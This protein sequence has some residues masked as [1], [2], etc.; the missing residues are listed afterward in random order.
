MSER[1]TPMNMQEATW[2]LLVMSSKLVTIM[3]KADKARRKNAS[4]GHH[5][6]YRAALDAVTDI[7]KFSLEESRPIAKFYRNLEIE[8]ERKLE[9]TERQLAERDAQLEV[10]RTA[11]AK[12]ANMHP[13]SDNS[14]ELRTAREALARID[15][16]SPAHP[17]TVG[18]GEG[19][20]DAKGK[21]E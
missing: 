18:C 1:P 10:A 19:S 3:Q 4:N 2:A 12:I 8:N 7:A 9:E 14:I 20:N 17:P 21:K 15:A 5:C 11:L 16:N 13:F 6:D